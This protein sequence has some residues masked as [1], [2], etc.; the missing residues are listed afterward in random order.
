MKHTHTRTYR[1]RVSRTY[2][3][4]YGVQ[5]TIVSLLGTTWKERVSEGLFGGAWLL[6]SKV[7][8]PSFH[9]VVLYG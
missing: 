3:S 6:F 1:G 2:S 4:N 9:G 8:V 7:L 5:I